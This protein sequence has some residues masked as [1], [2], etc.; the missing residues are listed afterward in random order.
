MFT[1]TLQKCKEDFTRRLHGFYNS[2]TSLCYKIVMDTFR[3]FLGVLRQLAVR[4]QSALFRVA[5]TEFHPT[6]TY[7]PDARGVL[8]GDHTPDISEQKFA[9][10]PP[11][12]RG[13][14]IEIYSCFP[15]QGQFIGCVVKPVSQVSNLPW[16]VVPEAVTLPAAMFSGLD[17]N[18]CLRRN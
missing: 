16:D 8:S 12:N 11:T 18:L 6:V 10:P 9:N 14:I 7:L 17:W 3:L 2:V 4:L 5:V 15:L 13:V 1:E